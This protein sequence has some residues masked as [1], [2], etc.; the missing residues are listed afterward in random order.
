MDVEELPTIIK[1]TARVSYADVESFISKIQ[2][3]ALQRMKD[4]LRSEKFIWRSIPRLAEAGGVFE[5]EALRMLEDDPDVVI[6]KGKQGK[7]AK[8]ALAKS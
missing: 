6:G 1:Q 8:L 4:A 2:K 5:T 3:R 7:I